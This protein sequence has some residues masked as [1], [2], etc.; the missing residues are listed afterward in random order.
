MSQN[1]GMAMPV[2]HANATFRKPVKYLVTI[3]S[4][5]YRIARL[6]LASRELVNEFDAAVAEVGSMTAGVVPEVGL[7]GAEWDVALAGHS[8]LERAG[9]ESFTLLQ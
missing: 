2:K 3:D 4:G 1:F 8:S 5:G 9:A 6:F 7:L